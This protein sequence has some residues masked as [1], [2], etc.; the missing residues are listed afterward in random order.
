MKKITAHRSEIL[1]HLTIQFY[2]DFGHSKEIRPALN[3]DKQNKSDS[4]TEIIHFHSR[5]LNLGDIFKFTVKQTIGAN[6]KILTRWFLDKVKISCR[7]E[8]YTFP[9]QKW[10]TNYDKDKVVRKFEMKLY[11]QVLW[12]SVS[13]LI[14]AIIMLYN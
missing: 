5:G 14:V 10:I 11:E 3:Q 12:N 13:V 7:K 2:G 8:S 9:F 1:E 4:L 6:K